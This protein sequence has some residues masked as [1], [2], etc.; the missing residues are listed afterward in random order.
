LKY[1]L[2]LFKI[3]FKINQVGTQLT[4]VNCDVLYCRLMLAIL[5]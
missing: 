2:G 3:D 1:N 5:S 4:K